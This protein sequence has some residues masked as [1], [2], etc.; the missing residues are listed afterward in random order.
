M[1]D[2]GCLGEEDRSLAKITLYQSCDHKSAFSFCLTEHFLQLLDP[3]NG[4]EATHMY[5][6]TL[7]LAERSA[8]HLLGCVSGSVRSEKD[9]LG[10]FH[11]GI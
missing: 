4:R 11:G 7:E 3:S 8:E 2:I 10:H 9:W 5:E 6:R 1:A